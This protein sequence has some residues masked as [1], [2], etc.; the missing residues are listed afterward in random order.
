MLCVLYITKD[1]DTKN[2][3]NIVVP[4]LLVILINII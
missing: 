4:K 2:F 3:L 1:F